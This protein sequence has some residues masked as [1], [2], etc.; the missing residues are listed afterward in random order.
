MIQCECCKGWGH[1]FKCWN[2]NENGNI[3]DLDEHMKQLKK[4]K[5]YCPHCKSICRQ[6]KDK[7]GRKIRGKNLK[8]CNEYKNDDIYRI[9]MMEESELKQYL[10]EE[11]TDLLNTMITGLYI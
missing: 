5:Y 2:E 4:T 6:K 8:N 1:V 7:N 11:F 3:L 9:D 10:H